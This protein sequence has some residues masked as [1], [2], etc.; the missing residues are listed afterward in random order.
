MTAGGG[1]G[2]GGYAYR[3]VPVAL[4]PALTRSQIYL[5]LSW[6]FI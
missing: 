1:R 3:S 4:A 6:S 5:S 2:Y